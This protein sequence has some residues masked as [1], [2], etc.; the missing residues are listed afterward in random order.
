MLLEE[1]KNLLA[2]VGA[3][4]ERLQGLVEKMAKNKKKPRVQWKITKK[5]KRT[6]EVMGPLRSK[7]VR[8]NKRKC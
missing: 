7:R 1:R 8:R 4:I 3:N 2:E 6:R 5:K